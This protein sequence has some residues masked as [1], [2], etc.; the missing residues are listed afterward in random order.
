MSKIYFSIL[1]H[2]HESGDLREVVFNT[3]DECL[4]DAFKHFLDK[5]SDYSTF[6]A[7]IAI[8]QISDM[9][10]KLV[11]L[12]FNVREIGFRRNLTGKTR[13]EFHQIALSK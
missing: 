1:G 13:G 10:I 3:L 7:N 8:F 9:Q 12:W 2:Y 5:S 11:D 4:D 6:D